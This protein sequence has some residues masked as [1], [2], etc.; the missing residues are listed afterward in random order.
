MKRP[1]E[2][3]ETNNS[4]R[5]HKVLYPTSNKSTTVRPVHEFQRC[6]CWLLVWRS[7]HRGYERELRIL[8]IIVSSLVSWIDK[9]VP[10]LSNGRYNAFFAAAPLKIVFPCQL[11]SSLRIRL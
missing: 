8:N 1:S 10:P 6:H 5:F 2:I 3:P 11:G 9:L 4:N 7:L